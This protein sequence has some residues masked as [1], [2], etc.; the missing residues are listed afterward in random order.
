M[1]CIDSYL[2]DIYSKQRKQV[3]SQSDHTNEDKSKI[4][5]LCVKG[6]FDFT[7]QQHILFKF[8]GQ[9]NE[10]QVSKPKITFYFDF[11]SK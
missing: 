3:I 7:M 1:V 4:A 5:H 9:V 2:Q 11:V 8:K 6:F 10:A